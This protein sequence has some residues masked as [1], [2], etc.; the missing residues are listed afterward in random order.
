L[1][2]LRIPGRAKTIERSTF[3]G[4]RCQSIVVDSDN[5]RFRVDND[6][7]IDINRP[8]LVRYFG[9]SQSVHIRKDAEV[10][11][12]FCFAGS[13]QRPLA[14]YDV[15]FDHNSRIRAVEEMCFSH[16]SLKTVCFPRSLAVLGKSC[17]V[18][19]ENSQN[20]IGMVAFESESRLAQI[21]E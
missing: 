17:F 11:G 10:L 9:A 13:S 1:E 5:A 12:R 3:A 7:L 21:E 2:E 20:M 8:R 15:L 18:G 14:I 16:C 4:C 19:S 6:F